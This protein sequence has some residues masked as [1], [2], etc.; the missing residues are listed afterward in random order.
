MSSFFAAGLAL[1]LATSGASAL[2]GDVIHSIRISNEGTPVDVTYRAITDVSVRQIGS[3]P[4]TRMSSVRCVWTGRVALE[5]RMT[6]EADHDGPPAV[7]V[8]PDERT[9]NG[10][11]HGDCMTNRKAI[12]TEMTRRT[13]EIRPQ[14]IAA[15]QADHGAAL[16]DLKTASS[17]ASRD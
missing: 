6:R 12:D 10:S 13:D 1:A 2:S 16:A 9:F 15:A 8:L 17:L 4:P 5:R 7:R 11:R 3:S 14:L